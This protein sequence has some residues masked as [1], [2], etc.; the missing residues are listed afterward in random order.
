MKTR[1]KP[2]FT[3]ALCAMLALWTLPALAET[4]FSAADLCVN[5]AYAGM[6][7]EEVTAVFGEPISQQDSIVP[8]TGEAQ[9]LWNYDGLTLTFTEGKLSAAEWTS[10]ALI[11]PRG[12]MVGDSEGT[13]CNAF[14]QDEAAA[15]TSDP[16]ERV[17]HAAG[18]IDGFGLL[19]PYGIIRENDGMENILYCTPQTPYTGDMEAN[20]TDTLY[21]VHAL[22]TFTLDAGQGSVNSIRWS[23]GAL[24][25]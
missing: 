16:T 10:A 15:Q 6:S 11:G 2:I 21:E 1:L 24:A 7:A 14:Q 18:N 12:L 17:L 25:E 19:P 20:P 4:A 23:L 22:L 8:A 9:S 5:S 13:V 3:L